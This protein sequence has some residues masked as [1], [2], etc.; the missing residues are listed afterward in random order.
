[1]KAEARMELTRQVE[2][3]K[4]APEGPNLL[5]KFILN[6]VAEICLAV[7]CFTVAIRLITAHKG[8]HL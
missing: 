4:L 8:R 3:I 1:M 2:K 7:G 5:L 6:A